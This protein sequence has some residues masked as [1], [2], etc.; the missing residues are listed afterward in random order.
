MGLIYFKEASTPLDIK[1]FLQKKTRA[2]QPVA[3]KEIY[4]LL[5]DVPH[6]SIR[7]ILNN[8]KSYGQA[9]QD[10]IFRTWEWVF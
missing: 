5:P 9:E 4:N 7:R 8:M 1:K 2:K 3:L 6:A 10:Q